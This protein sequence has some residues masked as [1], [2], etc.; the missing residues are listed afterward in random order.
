MLSHLHQSVQICYVEKP[1]YK[2]TNN[3][4]FD[5]FGTTT[6]KLLDTLSFCYHFKTGE[7]CAL[8][9]HGVSHKC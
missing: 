1:N 3:S 7:E 9:S 5:F 8:S 2:I 4:P 6:K